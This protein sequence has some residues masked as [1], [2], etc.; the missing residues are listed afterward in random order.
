MKRRSFERTTNF[1]NGEIMQEIS[2]EDWNKKGNE[3]FGKTR[4]RW[5]FQCPSCK[6]VQTIEDFV[7]LQKI[8][9]SLR[10]AIIF[11]RN[12]FKQIP[13]NVLSLAECDFNTIDNSHPEL[14]L[15]VK[16]DGKKIPILP[17][18]ENRET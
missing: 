8:G 18:F 13:K 10:S 5:R 14:I 16:E 6:N 9:V 15:I 2:V 3:L 12:N 17:F 7:K 4:V 1:C 11:C